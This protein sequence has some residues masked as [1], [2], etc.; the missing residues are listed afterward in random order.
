MLLLSGAGEAGAYT[1]FSFF[2]FFCV[3]GFWGV[4]GM[5]Y[6]VKREERGKKD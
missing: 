6:G 1:E 2:Y 3:I 4:W 5:G